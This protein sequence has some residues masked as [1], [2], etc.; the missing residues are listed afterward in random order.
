VIDNRR[1]AELPLLSRNPFALSVLVAGVNDNARAICLRPFENGALVDW[2]MN[3]GRNR[4]NE[5]LPDGAPNNAASVAPWQDNLDFSEHF[6]RDVFWNRVGKVDHDFTPSDRVFFRWGENERSEIRNTSAIPTGPVQDGQ[7]PLIRANRAIAGDWVHI[8]GASLGL[9][10][11]SSYASYRE[12]SPSDAAV[13]FDATEFGWPARLVPQSSN[14]SLARCTTSGSSTPTRAAPTLDGSI[15]ARR[16][17]R[18]S[19]LRAARVPT[20]VLIANRDGP[21]RS[22]KEGI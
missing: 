22:A 9:N 1:I 10:L 3:G 20:D 8:F 4:N 5:F 19:A 18:T 6:N 7:L 12:L 14:C 16:G 17:N 15:A 13:G 2:S 21:V 11:R